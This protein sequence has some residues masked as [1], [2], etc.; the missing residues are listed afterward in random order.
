M[1]LALLGL[2]LATASSARGK[3]AIATAAVGAVS[4]LD[5]MTARRLIEKDSA[6]EVS[7]SVTIAKPADELYRFWRDLANLPR[8]MPLVES[9]TPIDEKRSRWV[10]R[11]PMGARLEWTSEILEDRP[12]ERLAWRSLEESDLWHAGVVR[13]EKAAGDR[14]TI[15]RLQ[16]AYRTPVGSVGDV[17]AAMFPGAAQ[18]HMK[19]CLRPFKQ[20]METGEIA[21]TNGQPVGHGRR[22]L[23]RA[24][25][26]VVVPANG[27]R[28]NEPG[29]AREVTA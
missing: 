28:S 13:F 21:T 3:L 4:A 22:S 8:V 9:V 5:Y 16:M 15:V 7:Q 12:G 26:G 11:T 23:I 1:D 27:Q 20:L 14:G 29:K 6:L 18:E 10:A 17:V 25:E 19:Q 2:A 24:M